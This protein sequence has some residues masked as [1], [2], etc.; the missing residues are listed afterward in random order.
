MTDHDVFIFVCDRIHEAQNQALLHG[1]NRDDV[2]TVATK[3]MLQALERAVQPLAVANDKAVVKRSPVL[4]GSEIHIYGNNAT[5]SD[6]LLS[7]SFNRQTMTLT[8]AF[9]LVAKQDPRSQHHQQ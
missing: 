2:H 9:Y 5:P 3:P 7:V 8:E 4:L 6:F 1:Y